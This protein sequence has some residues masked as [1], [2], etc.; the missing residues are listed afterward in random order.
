MWK[1]TAVSMTPLCKSQPSQILM[2]FFHKIWEVSLWFV[3]IGFTPHICY[4][5]RG[6]SPGLN[7]G[8]GILRFGLSCDSA[9]HCVQVT[10]VSMTP[11][12]MSQRCQWL[13][14]ACHSGVNDSALH[15]T[16]VSMIP[17]CNN[18]F[19]FL[20]ANTKPYCNDK[21]FK[22]VYQGPL[23]DEKKPEVEKVV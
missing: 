16:A 2:S 5:K 20:L 13:R 19:R 17:V 1:V 14:Y 8:F 22:P 18:L 21:G 15:V 4:I 3:L 6:L 10:A 9:V 11:L 12:C 23:F 7:P